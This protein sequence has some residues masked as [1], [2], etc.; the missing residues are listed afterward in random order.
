[1]RAAAL[2]VLVTLAVS[3]GAAVLAE[4]GRASV[5]AWR[6]RERGA[7]DWILL[8][9][10]LAA[11]GVAPGLASHAAP[12]PV[13]VPDDRGRAALWWADGSWR[14][15][16][17]AGTLTLALRRDGDGA[18]SRVLFGSA[19]GRLALRS[20]RPERGVLALGAVPG[21]VL[22][23]APGPVAGTWWCLLRLGA[24]ERGSDS[25]SCAVALVAEGGSGA[26]DELSLAWLQGLPVSAPALLV[27]VPGRA[28]AWV[29]GTAD[30]RAVRLGVE[31]LALGSE[32]DAV[33]VSV[34]VAIELPLSEPVAAHAA[35]RGGLA[36]AFPG[37][38]VVWDERGELVAN[39]GGFAELA[40]LERVAPR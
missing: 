2:G 26:R 7:E 8:D 10:G 27:P 16:P 30:R 6:V 35:A 34:Q 40:V 39:R 24:A 4:R 17:L 13:L 1:M 15:A 18:A 11:R 37:A 25:A 12:G 14:P 19:D 32:R 5:A 36:V 9:E 3:H 20:A 28:E 33:Q 38:V 22:A 29:V 31:D 21:P 23:L